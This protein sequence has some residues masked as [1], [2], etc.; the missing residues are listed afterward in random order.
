MTFSAIVPVQ[1]LED[2]LDLTPDREASQ[3]A[4]LDELPEVVVHV[5]PRRDP[6][7]GGV[8]LTGSISS[9]ST[10]VRGASSGLFGSSS[11]GGPI[12]ASSGSTLLNPS[13]YRS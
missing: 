13:R 9:R 7:P 11:E 12:L 2:A 3:N 4:V 1:S 10:P 5:P 8:L 6:R